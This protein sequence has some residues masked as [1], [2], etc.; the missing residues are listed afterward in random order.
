MSAKQTFYAMCAA[1]L[2][3][4]AAL[5]GG[6]YGTQVLL[7]KESDKMVGLKAQVTTLTNEQTSLKVAKKQIA[8]DADLYNISKV[9]VPQ[10]KDQA[11]AV[12]QIVN[13]AS[14]NNV[15]LDSIN[16]PA[17]TL[18]TGV[19]GASGT[20]SVTATS[21]ASATTGRPALSQLTAV[22]KVPGVYSLQLTINSSTTQP[23]TYD[24]L[25]GFLAALE[26]NRQTAQVSTLDIQ[27]NSAN[28][29]LFSFSIVLNIYIKP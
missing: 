7:K 13:L 6:A 8:A 3:L 22:P 25:I 11:Q 21:G 9:I 12:R 16:F 14:A 2:L 1:V 15:A 17:S 29:R 26:Q 4:G 10:N 5:I 20:T 24:E 18:G 28:H 27:P 23:A 19:A